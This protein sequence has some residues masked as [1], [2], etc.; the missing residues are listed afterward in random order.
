MNEQAVINRV[1]NILLKPVSE[2]QV[3]KTETTTQREIILNYAVP[4]LVL[5]AIAAIIGN[6]LL[7]SRYGVGNALIYSLLITIVYPLVVMYLTAWVINELAPS[8]NS[9]KDFT[10]AFKLVVYSYTAVMVAA[11]IANLHW[12]IGWVGIFGLYSIYLFWTGVTPMMETPED[13]KL[14]YVLVSA[15]V[16]IGITLVLTLLLTP[17]FLATT[18]RSVL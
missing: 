9:K 8:F 12:T 18:V 7:S 6:L 17:L 3:V 15:L 14:G 4:L 13:K 16:L 5:G 2:W 11:I 10:A 1:K